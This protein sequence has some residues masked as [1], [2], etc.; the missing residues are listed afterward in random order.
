MRIVLLTLLAFL[1][2]AC[3]SAYYAGMEK[4]GVH[5]REILTDRVVDAKD[6]Q[7]DAKEQFQT[8]LERFSAMVDYD[9]GQLAE[10]Y[11]ELNAEFRASESRAEAVSD[12]IDG[13]Q[14]VAEALFAE[15]E[16]ELA[17]YS[18]EKLRRSSRNQLAATK[19]EYQRLITAMR[20]AESRMDPVLDTFRDQ[21]LFLKHNLNARAVAG[22]KGELAGIEADVSQL[23]QAMNDSIAQAEQFISGLEQSAQ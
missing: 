3:Q 1:F 15:W 9:G 17:Q 10:K 7:Q 5:K 11:A 23:I 21:V 2:V 13:V 16:A 12:R 4:L 19:R 8:A 14:D 20:R 6:A 22:L 18:S